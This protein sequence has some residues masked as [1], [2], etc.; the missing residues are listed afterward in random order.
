M[1][2][3]TGKRVPRPLKSKKI[4]PQPVRRRRHTPDRKSCTTPVERRRLPAS[5][6]RKGCGVSDPKKGMPNATDGEKLLPRPDRKMMSHVPSLKER[7]HA[8]NRK[9]GKA[10][11]P[12]GRGGVPRSQPEEGECH[13][14]NRKRGSA[15]L[16]TGR[17][18][19]ARRRTGR[20]AGL[21]T[22]CQAAGPRSCPV[23]EGRPCSPCSPRGSSPDLDRRGRAE[24]RRFSTHPRTGRGRSAAWT[25]APLL[26][27]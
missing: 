19:V 21:S 24:R 18:G 2:I 25:P 9:R 6:G 5:V 4:K 3:L 1:R 22:A 14:P 16:S 11:V 8:P 10:T 17:G 7:C 20:K 12:T 13:A 23:A 15:T 27:I 26:D